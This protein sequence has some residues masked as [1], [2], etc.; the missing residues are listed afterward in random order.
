VTLAGIISRV[1]IVFTKKNN[2]KMAF[3]TLEDGT[4]VIDCIVFPKLYAENPDIWVEDQAILI[5][6]KVD[7]RE[8]K[9]QVVV[10]SGILVDTKK[11]PID[12]IHE[13]FIKSGTP[14][15]VMEE[16]SKLFKTN[17][18]EHEI[19]VAVE[20][21]NNLKKIT[22]PYKVDYSEKLAK[23]VDKTLRGW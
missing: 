15:S 4:G 13:I 18:G 16:V 8:E 14:K 6:G 2:S 1:K 22:L 11:T 5:K 21:G 10:D 19:I 7:N 12:M 23:Q 17:P 3:V 20:T 9:L